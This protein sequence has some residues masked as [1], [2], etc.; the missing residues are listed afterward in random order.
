[1]FLLHYQVI[2]YVSFFK[3]QVCCHY[4]RTNERETVNSA[5][6]HPPLCN[7]IINAMWACKKNKTN[8]FPGS[9]ASQNY[10]V[11]PVC[12]SSQQFGAHIHTV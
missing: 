4:N 6:Y 12:S 5:V 2:L 11:P 1:M 3:L 8:L 9:K 10:N 7:Y